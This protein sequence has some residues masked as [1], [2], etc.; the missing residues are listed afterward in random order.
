MF[1]FR[2][3]LFQILTNQPLPIERHALYTVQEKAGFNLA[4]AHDETHRVRVVL[5]K[6]A[7]LYVLVKELRL[8]EARIKFRL[9]RLFQ[10]QFRKLIC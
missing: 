5:D 3:D 9:K 4:L 7:R 2:T 6:E 10:F 8:L 1:T